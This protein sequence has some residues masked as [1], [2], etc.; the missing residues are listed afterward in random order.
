MAYLHRGKEKY[1]PRVQLC[2]LDSTK[3]SS[4]SFPKLRKFSKCFPRAS[5]S[6]GVD[7]RN[8]NGAKEQIQK[9]SQ[10]HQNVG[11]WSLFYDDLLR[12]D[13]LYLN[14]ITLG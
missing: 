2:A 10:D 14:A 8:S 1:G 13:I 12:Q 3:Y 9:R 6:D 11:T 4:R 5:E 7:F